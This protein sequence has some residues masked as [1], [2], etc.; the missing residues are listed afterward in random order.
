MKNYFNKGN[1]SSIIITAVL[2]ILAANSLYVYA[3][4]RNY[5][6]L[7][8]RNLVFSFF[9]FI[10][11]WLAGYFLVERVILRAAVFL[12]RKDFT[13]VCAFCLIMAAFL[14]LQS[15]WGR[16]YNIL[17][18]PE[19]SI[20]VMPLEEK[21]SASVGNVIEIFNFDHQLGHASFNQ[22]SHQGD[23]L[24]TQ[25]GAFLLPQ[26]EPQAGASWRGR[27]GAAAYF[28]F[29]KRPDG[30]KVNV[31]ADGQLISSLDLYS[32]VPEKVNVMHQ[33]PIPFAERFFTFSALLVTITVGILV[34]MALLI[35]LEIKPG[36][37][38]EREFGWLLFA[39]PM[40][41]VW[42]AGLL[43]FWP[44]LLSPDSLAHLKQASSGQIN[45]WHS[46]LYTLM[47][48]LLTR[49]VDTPAMIA[50]FQILLLAGTNAWGLKICSRFGT[51]RWVLWLVALLMAVSLPNILTV[52][53]IWRDI[54]YS[55]S[56][57][58]LS[59]CCLVIIQT[60]G[61]WLSHRKNVLILGLMGACVVL[62]RRNGF[63]VVG[64]T[65]AVLAVVYRK[66]WVSLLVGAVVVMVCW[67][68]LTIPVYQWL[69][70]D[71]AANKLNSLILHHLG[72]HIQA[73]SGLTHE[74]ELFI[75][76]L[77]EP[78]GWD[79]Y[80]CFSVN[81][82]YF[83]SGFE[84]EYMA[85]NAGYA[86]GLWLRLT[87]QNPQVTINH[88]A[89]AGSM[90]WSITTDVYL[91]AS[92]LADGGWIRDNDL[93]YVQDSRWPQLS[94]FLTDHFQSMKLNSL[95][96]IIT[97][98]PVIYLLLMLVCGLVLV[99]RRQDWKYMLF[100][101][102]GLTHTAVLFAVSVAQDF[103]FQYP[104]YVVGIFSIALLAAPLAH[105]PEQSP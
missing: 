86:R 89:C 48:M 21:N 10:V 1:T 25:S 73:G 88:L 34:V 66:R 65:L 23:W 47:V 51:P 4:Q 35:R 45:N 6:A 79:E 101:L 30:G 58:G 20:E 74:D 104:V 15:G 28:T 57:L 90:L 54:P 31:F 99:M 43:A 17:F 27:T 29:M 94:V 85:E 80:Q 13:I 8:I 52:N 36:P 24:R 26:G 53:T 81:N 60:K 95:S 87:L 92:E 22:F 2:A 71:T 82:L 70:V 96:Y 55:T 105:P 75:L 49:I 76:E 16:Y 68:T 50:F 41:I 77:M 7:S 11:V 44:G 97:W 40:V 14:V 103:R 38:K 102:P 64:L 84:Q 61:E 42:C 63:P 32:P 98:K 37:V 12:K 72:A 3:F 91:Y 83:D 33:F 46:V 93:G 59:I 56:V 18:I 62:F 69:H 78:D 19:H 5:P 9:G 67:L 39:L 100:L